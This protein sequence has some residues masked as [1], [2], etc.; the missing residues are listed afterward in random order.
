MPLKSSCIYLRL[1]KRSDTNKYN[2]GGSRL[3][4]SRP[5]F[6]QGNSIY[7][8]A[9]YDSKASFTIT[10]KVNAVASQRVGTGADSRGEL[11]LRGRQRPANP[12]GARD[13]RPYGKVKV[14]QKVNAVAVVF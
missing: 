2:E 1:L 9:Q 12:K 4:L 3:V 5:V 11:S 7:F 13:G 6:Y 10:Q 14:R 8:Q